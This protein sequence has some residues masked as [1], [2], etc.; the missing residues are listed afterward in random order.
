M[1]TIKKIQLAATIVALLVAVRLADNIQPTT[2]ELVGS[3]ALALAG[4]VSAITMLVENER[5]VEQQ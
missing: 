5:R 1:K 4:G 2:D 3:V